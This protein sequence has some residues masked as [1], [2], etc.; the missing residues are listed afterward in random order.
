MIA[1]SK[2]IGEVGPELQKELRILHNQL[3]MYLN[4]NFGEIHNNSSDFVASFGCTILE[5]VSLGHLRNKENVHS[6]F[7]AFLMVT[8]QVQ[9]F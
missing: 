2:T 1:R 3:E 6:K 5:N 9:G 4:R 7:I 8:A